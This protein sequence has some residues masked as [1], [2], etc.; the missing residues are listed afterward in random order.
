MYVLV[1]NCGSATVK[2][3]LVDGPTGQVA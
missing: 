2:Y 3:A 1:I